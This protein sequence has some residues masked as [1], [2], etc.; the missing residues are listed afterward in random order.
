MFCKTYAGDYKVFARL[1][2]SIKKHNK[3][4]IKLVVSCPQNDYSLFKQFESDIIQIIT[5]ESYAGKYLTTSELRGLSIGYIN[6]EICKLA[7][8][9]TKLAG[10]YLCLD[11]DTIV[12]RDFFLSDFMYDE[13]VPFSVL[14]MDKDLACEKE[15]QYYWDF[16]IKEIKKIYDFLD[17]KT[18]V[19]KTCHGLQIINSDVV[20]KLKE[21]CNTLSFQYK[22]MIQ[23]APF[24]FTWYNVALQKFNVIPV[25]EIEPIFKYFHYE[26]QY[27]DAKRHCMSLDD[28][29]RQYVGI[30]M[31]SNWSKSDTGYQNPTSIEKFMYRLKRKISIGWR[32]KI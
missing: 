28:W 8:A 12:I 5:D 30:V 17:Y 6:Q 4:D 2:N 29:G 3:D 21:Y 20:M 16:R 26:G 31:N 9:E 10:N 32:R 14:S 22:D 27:L 18:P 1:L 19:Y 13:N 24:E 15:Y 7:F 11:S 23:Y 25:I